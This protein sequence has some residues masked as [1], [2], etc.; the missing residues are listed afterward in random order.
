MNLEPK[1]GSG[2]I[3]QIDINGGNVM[4]DHL[5]KT[6]KRMASLLLAAVMTVSMF[7]PVMAEEAVGETAKEAVVEI[8]TEEAA[9]VQNEEAVAETDVV[10]EPVSQLQEEKA[11][12]ESEAVAKEADDVVLTA[13]DIVNGDQ[14]PE[15]VIEN[16]GK[17]PTDGAPVVK[18]DYTVT[19]YPNRVVIKNNYE[20]ADPD[21]DLYAVI[22]FKDKTMQKRTKYVAEKIP[23][24]GPEVSIYHMYNKNGDEQPI[25]SDNDKDYTVFFGREYTYVDEDTG[26]T[27][28]TGFGIVGWDEEGKEYNIVD[29][30]DLSH[31]NIDPEVVPEWLDGSQIQMKAN[32]TNKM[33]IKISW[34]PDKQKTYKKY[35]LYEL[36][37][38]PSEK[39]G[40]KKTQRWPVDNAGNPLDPA[41][42][43]SVTLSPGLTDNILNSSLLYLLECFDKD[44]KSVDSY[45]TP[46][47]PYLL[48]VQSGF[49]FTC[50]Q[51]KDSSSM[52]Y[53]IQ[54]AKVNKE[55]NKS[56]EGFQDN[57][58][59][60]YG[61]DDFS[62]FYS[63]GDYPINNKL[64]TKA[65]QLYYSNDEP[66]I[67][68][69]K[70]GFC[71]VKTVAYINGVPYVSTP[72]N[73]LNVKE[74]PA[75]CYL[76]DIAGVI[77]DATDAKKH[78][79]TENKKRA[80]IHWK[81][82]N[83]EDP[84]EFE[85]EDVYI[86]V[87]HEEDEVDTCAKNGTLFFLGIKD[88][89][90]SI[91]AYE[92]LRSDSKNG[93]YKKVK[94]YAL[95]SPELIRL[96]TYGESEIPVYAMHYNSFVPEK[97]FY[98]AIRA[99][100]KT[101]STP[102]ARGNA[103]KKETTAD[104]VQHIS[105]YEDS[106]T[107][108]DI[109]WKHDD[110]VKQYWVYRSE[111]PIT[112]AD[113]KDFVSDPHN[114]TP[115]AKVSGGSAKK[116]SY[117]EYTYLYHE[118]IDKKATTDKEFYYFVRPVY[119]TKK[120]TNDANYNINLCSEVVKGKA[121]ARFVPIKNF[122]GVNYSIRDIQLSFNQAK[123]IT[124]Y[125]IWRMRADA[126]DT[127]FDDSW[128]PNVY[129]EQKEGESIEDLEDRVGAWTLDQWKPFFAK[130]GKNGGWEYVDSVWGNGK[131]TGKK[132]F[133][134]TT[135]EVGKYYYYL[136]QG[137]TSKSSGFVFSHTKQIMNQP[138]PVTGLEGVYS[139]SG[140]GIKL[141]WGINKKDR[142]YTD[143]LTVKLSMDKGGTWETASSGWVH[144][145]AKRG[146]DHQYLVKVIYDDGSKTVE[147][148]TS[149]IT[150]SLPSR[151]EVD[152]YREIYVGDSIDIGG[153]A[154]KNNGDTAS[155]NS[156]SYS[157][158]D[159]VLEGSNGHYRGNKPGEAWVRL[160]CAG[161]SK[162]VHVRVKSR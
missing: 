5:H 11:G 15:A 78:Q 37:E 141:K 125:R 82:F 8:Q 126:G 42:S 60:D 162:E 128:M 139:G 81:R 26:K 44:G 94:S 73:V 19:R 111:A 12:E 119:D 134:D 84:G 7:S 31:D 61:C 97:T 161:I 86:H 72:S 71:R 52:A 100:S 108:L 105:L 103:I 53:R 101:G 74:G 156:I 146:V 102:G 69:S 23:A 87:K 54:L 75:Q 77:Y 157:D 123:T 140:S 18:G 27:E 4:K 1:R 104:K 64:S 3:D 21:K 32:V 9:A 10:S 136:I 47:A 91:K 143:S 116:Y 66:N 38:D 112:D 145:N 89:Q 6:S 49:E 121:T 137:A 88:D 114:K 129:N 133:D 51:S 17:E 33:Q 46:V 40:Y 59:I 93:T 159:G 55:S 135:V 147:S 58:S 115:Y 2:E 39:S 99:V 41:G 127:E 85:W 43:K 57:W 155:I 79:N 50:T 45:V 35:K 130:Y 68:I 25:G 14:L 76:M 154:V 106:S 24:G 67:P 92:L 117:D 83:K 34:T 158:K 149:K 132:T 148:K 118:Y 113:I 142:A 28:H 95:N 120:A 16:L 63:I 13:E 56:P 65:V 144:K 62:E 29:T 70:P 98:Y 124:E 36:V 138:L 20:T 151:I 122:A 96:E 90:S 109:V 131:A 152:D 107:S 48:Q 22:L 153:R 30:A 80:Q 160:S 110:C 150:C